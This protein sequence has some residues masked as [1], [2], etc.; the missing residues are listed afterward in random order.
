MKLGWPQQHCEIIQKM[1][2]VC[3]EKNPFPV[4]P[5]EVKSL[6]QWNSWF[7]ISPYDKTQWFL[8]CFCS[9]S[10]SGL[11][12]T[13]KDNF[14]EWEELK[15]VIRTLVNSLFGKPCYVFWFLGS[16]QWLSSLVCHMVY[17]SLPIKVTADM[18]CRI[19]GCSSNY[20]NTFI[21]AHGKDSFCEEAKLNQGGHWD[22][23]SDIAFYW[24]QT[25]VC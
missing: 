12:T 4:L 16:C 8:M 17:W 3:L 2:A 7:T 21:Y 25:N 9:C 22:Y 5:C 23:T 11:A 14:A 18:K 10:N 13:S 6:A 19:F 15:V 24:W 20:L 1:A